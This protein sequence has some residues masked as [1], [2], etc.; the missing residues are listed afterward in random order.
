MKTTALLA[1]LALCS[2]AHAQQDLDAVLR[3]HLQ[4]RNAETVAQEQRAMDDSRDP[5]RRRKGTHNST[6][7]ISDRAKKTWTSTGFSAGY[8]VPLL[9]VA[10]SFIV[11]AAYKLVASF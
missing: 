1:L 8:I 3:Q 11:L 2:V 5:L 10:F 9:T 6:V 7:N 4:Q